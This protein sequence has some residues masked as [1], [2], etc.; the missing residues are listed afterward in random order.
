MLTKIAYYQI[1]EISLIAYLGI[2]ALLLFIATALAAIRR[3]KD[4]RLLFRWHHRLAYVSIILAI[5]HGLLGLFGGD[6]IGYGL[7]GS[8]QGKPSETTSI[9]SAGAEVFNTHCRVCHYNGGNMI[10]PN[11]PIKGSLKLKD[12]ETFLGFIR[13]ATSPM[14]SFPQGTITD[15]EARELYEYITSEQGLHLIKPKQT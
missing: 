9:I 12:F 7:G 3:R 8:G 2:L 10:N 4:G 14:P 1:F 5:V 13:N 6:T 15:R 11:K